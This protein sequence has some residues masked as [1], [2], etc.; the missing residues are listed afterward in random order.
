MSNAFLLSAALVA[1]PM[2]RAADP[3]PAGPVPAAVRTARKIFI[4][5]GGSDS[6]LF[7]HPF[8]GTPDRP[9]HQFYSIVQGWGRYDLVSDPSEADL[10][11]ELSLTTPYRPTNP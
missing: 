8:S 6:V 7:P 11:F 1:I 3:R 5:H 4:S 9:Y 2:V 10:V